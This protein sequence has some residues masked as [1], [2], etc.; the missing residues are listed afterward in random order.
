M[1]EE[2]NKKSLSVLIAE[3]L[4]LASRYIRQEIKGTVEEAVARPIRN[5]GKWAALA[6]AASSLFTL[7]AI[8]LA[9]GAFQ[10]LAEIV[11]ATWIAYLIIGG[12]LLAG[13]IAT[14]ASMRLGKEPDEE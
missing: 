3:L 1:T 11:G 9:V 8:F 4:E 12:L 7:A 6:L 13:G 14:A 5:A 10:L 2:E